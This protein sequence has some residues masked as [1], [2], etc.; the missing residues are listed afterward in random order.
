MPAGH[1]DPFFCASPNETLSQGDIVFAPTVTVWSQAKI[2]AVGFPDAPRDIAVSVRGPLWKP[3]KSGNVPLVTHESAWRPGIVV[4]HDC[5]LDKQFNELVDELVRQGFARP[6]AVAAAGVQEDL[7]P[8]VLIAPLMLYTE[9]PQGWHQ[10]IRDGNRIGYFPLP[11]I[12]GLP[13]HSFAVDLSQMTTVHWR[14]LS[15]TIASLARPNVGRLRYKLSEMFAFRHLSALGEIA[16]IVGQRI[17]EIEVQ[18]KSAKKASLI[19]HLEDGSLRHVAIYPPPEDEAEPEVTRPAHVRSRREAET[20][21]SPDG[22]LHGLLAKIK[23][24]VRR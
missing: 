10:G 14:L 15:P 19:L 18:K 23:R 7:D 12:P 13:Q 24:L 16:E 2:V 17:V 3:P 22:L 20:A 4:T 9:I 1:A 6:E 8:L 11:S 21:P 5:A